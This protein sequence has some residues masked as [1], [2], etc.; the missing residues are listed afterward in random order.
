MA[1]VLAPLTFTGG[2][3][4]WGASPWIT[5]AGSSPAGATNTAFSNPFC[6]LGPEDHR[7]HVRAA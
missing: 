6:W 7:L 1:S 2:R 4:H 3:L 5:L